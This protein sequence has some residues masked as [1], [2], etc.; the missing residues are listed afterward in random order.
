MGYAIK[1]STYPDLKNGNTTTA[2][3]DQNKL[4]QFSKQA[5]SVSATKIELKDQDLEQEMENFLI[6]RWVVR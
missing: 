3:T 6:L 2:K 1:K 4:K 5:K